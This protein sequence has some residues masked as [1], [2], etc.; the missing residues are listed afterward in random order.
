MDALQAQYERNRAQSHREDVL[1][2]QRNDQG[3]ATDTK[4]VVKQPWQVAEESS[5]DSQETDTQVPT[6]ARE[7]GTKGI[8]LVPFFILAHIAPQHHIDK[9]QNENQPYIYLQVPN[10][11][12]H[13]KAVN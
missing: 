6:W 11:I 9:D 13:P 12:K 7:K 4:E 3:E 1:R 10:G 5:S 2:E 8:P